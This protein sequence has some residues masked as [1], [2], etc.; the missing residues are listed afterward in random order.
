MIG[1]GREPYD[2]DND[3]DAE[4][5]TYRGY[6]ILVLIEFAILSIPYLLLWAQRITPSAASQGETQGTVAPLT[7]GGY[8]LQVLR[9]WDIFDVLSLNADVVTSTVTP[10]VT[11]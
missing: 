4:D 3:M 8:L 6:C 10:K 2:D 5:K 9:I 11:V 7:L 1:F